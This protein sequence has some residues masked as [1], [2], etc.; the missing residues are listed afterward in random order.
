MKHKSK[1][2]EF[3]SRR[4]FIKTTG[5]AV[6]GG[7][8]ATK[9]LNAEPIPAS[10]TLKVGLIG[11]GGRGTGAAGQALAADK[12]VKLTAMADA[13]EDRL[14]SSLS[15]LEKNNPGKVDVPPERRFVGFNAFKK[16]LESDIDVVILATPPGF[17]PQHLEESVKAGKHIFCEKPMAV[18]APGY[19]KV[20]AAVAESKKKNLSL[21]A[22]F[23]WRYSNA[24][25]AAFGRV[26]DGAIGDVRAVYATYNTGPIWVHPRKPDWSDMQWQMRNWYYFTWLSGDHIVEQA[27]HSV[28][29]IAWAFGD[30]S[31]VKVMAHGGRQVRNEPKYGH[32]YDHFEV[33]Y[34]FPNNARAFLFCR[35]MPGC[36]ND[37]SDHIMGSTGVCDV[38]GFRRI[39]RI[40]GENAWSYDGDYNNMYQTEH[41]KLF[42]S[43]RRGEPI[44]DGDRMANS[45]MMAIAGRMSAYTGQTI[46]W[47]EA[48][49]SE[50]DWSPP[51]YSWDQPVSVP[52]VA[53]PGVTQFV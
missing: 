24:E 37:N 46:T 48:V 9:T 8:F 25:R 2:Q 49:N 6:A 29:K 35:Q 21:V 51:S 13:F 53:M 11:C 4:E 34:E 28:D 1:I 14:T 50:K 31:P 47:E 52:P 26:L 38:T 23:C 33:V 42:A 7:L 3:T 16:V 12:N 43:I 19:R 44:N 22:G 39:H 45:T 30:V 10:E 20:L 18:D 40:I 36:S 32:I 41:D 15:G 17:R 27:V 5:I